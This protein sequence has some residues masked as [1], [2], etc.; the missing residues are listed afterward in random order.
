MSESSADFLHSFW[1]PQLQV[2]GAIVSLR[3]TVATVLERGPYPLPVAQALGEVLAASALFSAG[4]KQAQRLSIQLQDAGAVRLLFAECVAG[5]G[6]RGIARIAEEGELRLF[7]PQDSARMAISIETGAE[8]RYQGIVALEG[9]S[10]AQ[11]FTGYFERSE[12]LDTR[13]LLACDGGLVAAG[14]LLQ[15][16]PVSTSVT[17]DP[18]GWNRL[19]HLLATVQSAEL[20]GTEPLTLLER[21]FVEESVALNASTAMHFACTCSRERVAQVLHALGRGECEAAL[22]E[23]GS[24]EITCEFCGQ[25]QEF[26]AVE[27]E[28]L[29]HPVIVPAPPGVM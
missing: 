26:D 19:G 1:F 17:V 11:A 28:S 7:P 25:R 15:R 13:L 24:I 8:Q 12:Q 29:F 9:D 6:L 3:T 27:V 4:L 5:G 14:L 10:L 16:M 21:L 23:R 20:L 18:D 2:R 22:A